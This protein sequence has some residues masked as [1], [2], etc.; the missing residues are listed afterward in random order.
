MRPQ[1]V[2]SMTSGP[3]IS[4]MF[5]CGDSTP[6]F[7]A[8]F[9]V[10]V[11][12]VAAHATGRQSAAVY[13]GAANGD[14]A[15]HFEIFCAA[16]QTLRVP[17]QPHHVRAA[18]AGAAEVLLVEEAA[19]VVLAGGDV[20][21]GWLAFVSSGLDLALRRAAATGAVLLGISAGAIHLGTHG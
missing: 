3:T 20:Q 11:V 6:L 7:S 2:S 17:L 14:A 13:L 16:V 19:L 18:T 10:E 9:F 15:D 12:G 4:P 21:L 1:P 8:A 5:L